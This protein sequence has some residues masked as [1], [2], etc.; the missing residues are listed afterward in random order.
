MSKSASYNHMQSFYRE[1]KRKK[2]YDYGKSSV[3]DVD[4][5]MIFILWFYERQRWLPSIL[6][7]YFF[8]EFDELTFAI[9]RNIRPLLPFNMFCSTISSKCSTKFR[10]T[11]PIT[12]LIFRMRGKASARKRAGHHLFHSIFV[13]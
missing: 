3:L 7:T 12:N 9:F 5:F 10:W 2:N 1:R 8:I 4:L 11:C 6:V 13:E